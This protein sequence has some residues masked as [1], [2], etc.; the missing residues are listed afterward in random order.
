MGDD[1]FF[2]A[3]NADANSAAILV[4]HMA[5]NLKSRWTD[6]LTTDGEKPNRDRDSEFELTPS[7]TREDLM[8]RWSAGWQPVF[9]EL[10]RLNDADLGRKVYLRGQPLSVSAALLRQLAHSV[11]WCPADS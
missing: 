10:G 5:G 7:D 11:G 9:D 1:A 3:P 2:Q 6:F 4:K 8:T